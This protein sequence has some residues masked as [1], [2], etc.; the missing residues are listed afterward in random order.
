MSSLIE[1][2]PGLCRLA[3][4]LV[5]LFC[6]SLFSSLTVSSLLW[7]LPGRSNTG[8]Q[9]HPLLHMWLISSRWN[10]TKYH[11]SFPWDWTFISNILFAHFMY[12]NL[13][14]ILFNY[15]CI[16][17]RKL[18]KPAQIL[19]FSQRYLKAAQ[20]RVRKMTKT[21]FLLFRDKDKC[22]GKKLYK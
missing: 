18:F 2:W 21:Q 9:L 20:K 14:Y 4:H 22:L 7:A 6:L 3:I 19:F 5:S 10:A 1:Q 17:L 13:F 11:L 12:W 8:S 16:G 15:M